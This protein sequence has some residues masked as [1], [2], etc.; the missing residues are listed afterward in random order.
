MKLDDANSL[1]EKLD[2]NDEI[3]FTR[4]RFDIPEGTLYFDGNSLGPLTHASRAAI[5]RTVEHEWRERLIR[6]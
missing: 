2:A 5:D 3:A 6:S 4:A 1:A